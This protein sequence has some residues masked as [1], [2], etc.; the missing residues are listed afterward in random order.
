MN[1]VDILFDVV[2]PD[3]P[4]VTVSVVASSDGGIT[5]DLPVTSVSGDVGAGV[6]RGP[7]K[8][9]IWDF[10]QDHPDLFLSTCVVKITVL[11]E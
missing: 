1:I 7:G 10:A 3:S 2:D 5:W 11:D 9:I 4:Q 8:A 6:V